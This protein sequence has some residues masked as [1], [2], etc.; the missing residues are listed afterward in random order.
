[1]EN[2]L[3]TSINYHP[4]THQELFNLFVYSL[5]KMLSRLSTHFNHSC[6]TGVNI[7]KNAL[8][9]SLS[10]QATAPIKYRIQNLIHVCIYHKI[11]AVTMISHACIC[12]CV[13]MSSHENLSR[14]CV[15]MQLAYAPACLGHGRHVI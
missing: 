11:D 10:Q 6:Y 15:L 4:P 14:A 13:C 7:P 8:K 9:P 2:E 3:P 5:N 12:A 1:M